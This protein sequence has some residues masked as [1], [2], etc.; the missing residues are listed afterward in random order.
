MVKKVL[1]VDDDG[2]MV[3]TLKQGLIRYD[4]TFMVLTAED[5]LEAVERLKEHTMSIVVTD[6]KM[7]RM[8]G[9]SL[10]ATS[11]SITRKSRSSSSQGSALRRWSGR[12]RKAERPVTFPSL[13]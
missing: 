8:D 11:W 4:D 6:L 2:A 13:S 3:Q 9:F 7:P 12:Q 5:G 1:I 10:F